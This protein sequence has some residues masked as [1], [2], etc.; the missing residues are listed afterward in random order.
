VNWS[1][2]GAGGSHSRTPRTRSCSWRCAACVPP[3]A[4]PCRGAW[5][6]WRSVAP[7]AWQP[8]G[9]RRRR[10]RRG[11]SGTL[12]A[13]TAAAAAA[14][15]PAAAAATAAAVGALLTS[16]AA[17]PSPTSLRAPTGRQAAVGLRQAAAAWRQ[18]LLLLAVQS[19]EGAMV[20]KVVLQQRA[21]GSWTALWR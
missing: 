12:P 6:G 11:R 5:G 15:G 8:P 7:G 10:R 16:A 20:V 2:E 14:G 4:P 21:P 13:A 19:A 3:G 17:A 1:D 18:V 9:R